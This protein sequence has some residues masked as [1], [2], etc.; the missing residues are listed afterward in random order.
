MP[1]VWAYFRPSQTLR[2]SV[3]ALW[4]LI[5]FFMADN[6]VLQYSISMNGMGKTL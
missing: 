4:A 1:R 2:M 6:E 3:A 5:G